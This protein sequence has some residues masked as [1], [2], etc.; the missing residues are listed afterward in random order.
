MTRMLAAALAAVLLPCAAETVL[1]NDPANMR[2]TMKGD[3]EKSWIVLK[4]DTVPAKPNTWYRATAEIR[5]AFKPGPGNLR[6]RVR[7]VGENDKSIVY[8]NIAVLKPTL[9]NYS[10]YS[11]V[12]LSRPNVKG[13]QVYY[14]LSKLDG[15]ASFR[16]LKLEEVSA[17][18]AEKI[19]SAYQV[20]SAFFAPA[21]YAWEG[22]TELPWGYRVSAEFLKREQIPAK[23]VFSVPQLKLKASEAAKVN[24]HACAKLKLARPLKKGK[25]TVVMT[26]LDASGKELAKEERVLRVIAR[27][28]TAVRLPV[29]TVEIDPNGN[30]VINGKPVL[31]N[32]LYHV[33]T[34]AEVKDVAN[35][36]FNTVIA[37]DRTPESYVKMLSW[38]ARYD[39]YPDCMIKRLPEDKLDE[40]LKVIGKHP[41][42]ISF[43][44]EDEPD[45]KDYGPD[46]IMPRVKQIR[47]T[48]PGRPLRISCSGPDAVKRY[49]VCAE[50]MSSHHYVIPFGGLPLQVKSTE[51]VVDSFPLPR[52]H[53]PHMTLQSWVHWHDLTRKPQTP[54]QTRSLAYIALICGAKGLWWYSFIDK[55]SWD[56]RSV[57]SVWT[58]FKGLNAE[59]ADLNDVILTGSR[60]EIKT[61]TLTPDGKEIELGKAIQSKNSK[62]QGKEVGVLCAGWQLPQPPVEVNGTIDN[63]VRTVV[64]AVNTMKTPVRARISGLTVRDGKLKELFADDE[65]VQVRAGTAEIPVAPETTRVFEWTK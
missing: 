36:G 3:P 37:W 34:E 65:T 62:G 6:F 32:G 15:T 61:V 27:P 49:S 46:K 8:A 1:M 35:A 19:R 16:N 33:Y 55:G 21:V 38:L 56:V 7:Q 26:A 63:K 22:E 42:I 28:K 4:S 58:A 47:E 23:I 2:V 41:S 51:T 20:P 39:L 44:P 40:L 24:T 30:T 60:M 9:L 13:L 57:P 48:C 5:T 10:V 64:I 50:I 52:K 53:S 45:I 12:F 25:Y 14:Q 11:D 18:E 29:K 17:A 43:D 31:L 59:L 54:E